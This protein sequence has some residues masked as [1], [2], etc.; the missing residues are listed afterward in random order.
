VG[1]PNPFVEKSLKSADKLAKEITV[2][3]EKLFGQTKK[4]AKKRKKGK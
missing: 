4:K 3:Q 1:I 2:G